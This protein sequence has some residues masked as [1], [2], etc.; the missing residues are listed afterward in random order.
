MTPI[1][2]LMVEDNPGDV[3]LVREAVTKS[4]V[5]FRVTVVRDGVEAMSYLRREGK[6]ADAP[7]PDLM[8]LDLKLP[9]KS[10]REVL[11]DMAQDPAVQRMPVV[12]LSSSRSELELAR[13]SLL[14]T[15]TFMVKPG[16]FSEYVEMIR[17]MEAF[18]NQAERGR[19]EGQPA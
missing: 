3:I 9:R 10:G 2:V 11:R 18:R 4:N 16:T 13:S 17:A 12:V 8:V 7:R 1:D 19:E 6:F 15:Q 14:R 5:P